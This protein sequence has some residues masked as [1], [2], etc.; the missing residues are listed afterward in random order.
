MH[1]ENQQAED[2]NKGLLHQNPNGNNLQIEEKRQQIRS[3]Q[4]TLPKCTSTTRPPP[5][6]KNTLN[7][8]PQQHQPQQHP[9]QEQSQQHPH[10]EQS[11][12]LPHQQETNSQQ[13]HPI[14]PPHTLPS[15]SFILP[16]FSSPELFHRS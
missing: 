11:H 15:S 12:Q 5:K 10:Q 9:H 6:K 13:T 16:S 8:R 3:C 4:K 14:S 2:P 1:Q 7:L